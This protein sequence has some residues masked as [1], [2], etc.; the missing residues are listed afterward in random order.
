MGCFRRGTCEGEG[1]VKCLIDVVR[2][3]TCKLALRRSLIRSTEVQIHYLI[4]VVAG[5][6]T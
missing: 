5:P 1:K 2:E 3:P 4:K 6:P